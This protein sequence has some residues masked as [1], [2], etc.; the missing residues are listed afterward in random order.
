MCDGEQNVAPLRPYGTRQLQSGNIIGM[1]AAYAQ[2]LS[3]GR[4]YFQKGTTCQQRGNQFSLDFPPCLEYF[5]LSTHSDFTWARSHKTK[6]VVEESVAA[7]T[8]IWLLVNSLRAGVSSKNGSGLY[9]CRNGFK[10]LSTEQFTGCSEFP[11]GLHVKGG[12]LIH[13]P[14]TGCSGSASPTKERSLLRSP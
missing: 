2:D 5:I 6:R 7:S 11:I 12:N 3:K 8:S 14:A 1:L 9:D 10:R 13:E 4:K